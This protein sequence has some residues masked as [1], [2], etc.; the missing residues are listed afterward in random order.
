M[1]TGKA[2]HTRTTLEHARRI[3][4]VK[5]KEF[6]SLQKKYP[7]LFNP[8]ITYDEYV[9]AI[10]VVTTR[11]IWYIEDG[12]SHYS[13]HLVPLVDLVNCAQLNR[14]D[15]IHKTM[16]EDN[17]IVTRIKQDYAA[18]EQ[19]FENYGQANSHYFALHGFSIEPNEF[20]CV[21]IPVENGEFC[22]NL[23]RLEDL[24]EKY[25]D[26]ELVAKQLIP[27]INNHLK[28][29]ETSLEQ[30]EAILNS[31]TSNDLHSRR[32]KESVKFRMTEK[33]LLAS[34]LKKLYEIHQHSEL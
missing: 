22:I 24:F 12:A 3:L 18:G 11:T 13:P 6:T 1:F 27:L 19:V 29:Y 23:Y 32:K 17:K 7:H 14:L 15:A 5:F 8:L 26:R 21:S 33:R 10:G 30:D 16:M 9:W 25:G 28:N 34:V 31:I 2:S 20:D 4:A